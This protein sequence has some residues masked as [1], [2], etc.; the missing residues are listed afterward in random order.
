MPMNDLTTQ[1]PIGSHYAHQ[2]GPLLFFRPSGIITLSD[3]QELFAHMRTIKQDQGRLFILLDA[4][5]EAHQ[6]PDGRTW[7][8]NN[9]CDANRPNGVAIARASFQSRILLKIFVRA[10]QFMN[11]FDTPLE[12]FSSEAE[13]RTFLAGLDAAFLEGRGHVE[14]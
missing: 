8:V 3:N 11:R 10:A 1:L 14:S 4:I 13:A 6:H 5:H 7:G 12:F 2:E 9:I